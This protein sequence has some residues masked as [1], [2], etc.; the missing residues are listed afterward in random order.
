MRREEFSSYIDPKTY[1]GPT[2]QSYGLTLLLRVFGE[3]FS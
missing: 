2:P 3:E 1:G